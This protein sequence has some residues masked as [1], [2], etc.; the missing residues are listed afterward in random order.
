M[1]LGGCGD[2]DDQ[3]RR[4]ATADVAASNAVRE[5]FDTYKTAALERDGAVAAPLIASTVNEFYGEMRELALTGS[6][7]Q[8]RGQTISAQLT[9]YLMRAE[10]DRKLLRTAAVEELVQESVDKGLV[11]AQGIQRTTIGHIDVTGDRAS[12][13]VSVNGKRAGF[14]FQFIRENGTWKIDVQPLLTMANMALADSAKEEGLSHN[15]LVQLLLEAQYGPDQIRRLR[16]PV[17]R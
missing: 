16:K 12:A 13:E 6:E 7:R 2:G 4:D 17:G 3:S 5:T 9:V 15:A 1:L 8:I 10:L 14:R 11:G